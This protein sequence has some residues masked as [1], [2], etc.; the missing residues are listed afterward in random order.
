[1]FYLGII[2]IIYAVAVFLIAGM[3]PAKIW[4]MPKIQGFV[5]ILGNLG[6]VIFFVVW[7]IIALGFGIWL[8]VVNWPG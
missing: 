2:L 1:M 8:T 3:K 7:G 4:N 5:K 6:T